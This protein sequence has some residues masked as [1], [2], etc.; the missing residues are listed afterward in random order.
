MTQA[1]V[2]IFKAM[3]FV[4]VWIVL[5]VAAFYAFQSKYQLFP[6]VMN[7]TGKFL[8]ISSFQAGGS[9]SRLMFIRFNQNACILARH[10]PFNFEF[11]SIAKV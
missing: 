11:I 4:I 3:P 9:N 2:N 6:R 8:N 5:I 10:L 1:K 7:V